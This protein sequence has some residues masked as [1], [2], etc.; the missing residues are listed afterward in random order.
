MKGDIKFISWFIKEWI[1][2]FKNNSD[3]ISSLNTE[4]TLLQDFPK[5]R[6]IDFIEGVDFHHYP[7]LIT[8]IQIQYPQYSQVEIKNAIWHMPH[9][10]LI[11]EHL[12]IIIKKLQIMIL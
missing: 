4:I 11:I 6:F 5:I 10:K 12:L 8:E 2:R 1:E 9:L 7:S 3:Y